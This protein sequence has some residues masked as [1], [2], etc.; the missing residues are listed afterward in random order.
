M[1]IESD[2]KKGLILNAAFAQFGR[3]GFR[4]TSMDDIARE[5]DISR[6]SIY[7][8]FENKEE[9]LRELSAALHELTLADAKRHLIAK[10]IPAPGESFPDLSARVE[11]ALIDRFCPFLDVK[12]NSEHGAEITN[13]N[14]RLCGDIVRASQ[15]RFRDILATALRRSVRSG[16]IDLKASNLTASAAAEIIHLSVAGLKQDAPD[17]ATFQARVATFVG[18]F[19]AGLA[20][21]ASDPSK[22]QRQLETIQ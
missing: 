19:F 12:T 11:A 7:S 18:V 16:E 2:T 3:Y 17:T 20:P 8:Y 1:I 14:S 6:A 4:K 9:I 22:R 10:P 5:A 13:E 15:I 21:K